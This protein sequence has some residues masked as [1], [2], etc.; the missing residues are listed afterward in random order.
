MT[1]REETPK[2]VHPLRTIYGTKVGCRD[3]VES[4]RN[5]MT[6]NQIAYSLC[7]KGYVATMRVEGKPERWR[8]DL[9]TK[10]WVQM[11]SAP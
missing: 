4:T 3:R 2:R 6:A 9:D 7:K 5:S 10:Q 8:Y 1:D 11:E